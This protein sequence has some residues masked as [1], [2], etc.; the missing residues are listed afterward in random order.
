V[1]KQAKKKKKWRKKMEEKIG[2]NLK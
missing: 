1:N 2:H